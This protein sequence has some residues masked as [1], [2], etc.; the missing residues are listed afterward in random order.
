MESTEI[1]DWDAHGRAPGRHRELSGE[2]RAALGPRPGG[3]KGP[4]Q[5][6][7]G[8]GTEAAERGCPRRTRD[9]GV[10]EILTEAQEEDDAEHRKQRGHHDAQERGQLARGGGGGGPATFPTPLVFAGAA[11]QAVGEQRAAL[12]ARHGP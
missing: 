12:R 3:A 7:L 9:R 2:H 4:Q 6:E 11:A 10:Q 1:P 5:G 8:V